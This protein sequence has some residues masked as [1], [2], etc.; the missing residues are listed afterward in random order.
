MNGVHGGRRRWGWGIVIAI[1]SL[2]VLNGV[3]WFFIGPR[4]TWFEQ[5]TGV[6]L[7]EFRQEYPVVADSMS[8]NARQV[9]IWFTAFGVLSALV[10][11]EGFRHG[12]GWAWI[13]SW[14]LVAALAA[15]GLSYLAAG[16]PGFLS[17]GGLLMAALAA[18]G[19]LAA[20]SGGH[21]VASMPHARSAGS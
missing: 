5:A 18:V 15:L 11:V 16:E 3:T 20:R 8:A 10:G 14:V 1:G 12:S 19:L 7:S 21:G 13:A 6:P 17:L 4:I 9:A 2:L